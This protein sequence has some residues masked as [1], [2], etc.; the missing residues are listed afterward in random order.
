MRWQ[1]SCPS[2]MLMPSGMVHH[3]STHSHY[4]EPSQKD[5]ARALPH[6]ATSP[7]SESHCNVGLRSQ[8]GE[9]GPIWRA[10]QRP[11]SL[12]SSFS[13]YVSGVCDWLLHS[14][15]WDQ[16]SLTYIV[17]AT[18]LHSNHSNLPCEHKQ[19]ILRDSGL[20]LYLCTSPDLWACLFIYLFSSVTWQDVVLS[21]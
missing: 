9:Q 4:L 21:L 12:R 6:S 11:G 18:I 20:Q 19:H 3:P 10:S 14:I 13:L 1:W 7:L 2:S 5:R 17:K 16:T 15:N 8:T